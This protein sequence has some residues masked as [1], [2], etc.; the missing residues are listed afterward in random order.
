MVDGG[1]QATGE[2]TLLL[3]G[4]AR[5]L[6]PL[7]RVFLGPSA[8]V[9]GTCVSPQRPPATLQDEGYPMLFGFSN[10]CPHWKVPTW[11][12]PGGLSM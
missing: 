4:G 11:A 2:Q 7:R 8:L 9:L 10:P 12:S 6:F 1:E 5:G 3:P